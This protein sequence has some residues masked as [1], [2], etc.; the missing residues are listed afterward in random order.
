MLTASSPAW[1]VFSQSVA[2]Y[3][4][5]QP[6]TNVIARIAKPSAGG[7][8]VIVPDLMGRTAAQASAMLAAVGLSPGVIDLFAPGKPP[9]KV[10]DQ[11]PSFGAQV[12]VGSLV[13]MKV[14]KLQ[15]GWKV[16]PPLAGLTKAQAVA[17]V[18]AA[19]LQPDPDDVVA[20]GKPPG[21]VFD[22]A[23][24]AGVLK[25]AGSTVAF[26]VA[27]SL[28]VIVP[29]VVGLGQA[30][31]QAALAAAGLGANVSIEVA[32]L[33]PPGKVFDQN[34]NAGALVGNGTSIQI[35]IAGGFLPPAVAIIPSVF[36]KTKAQAMAILAGV[37]FVGDPIEVVALG[38]PVGLVFS[39][40]PAGGTGA[41]LGTV[42][43]FKV[44]KPF[45]VLNVAVPNL[46][47]LTPFQAKNALLALGLGTNGK[48][49]LKLGKPFNRVYSQS[50]SPNVFVPK[51][52]VISWKANP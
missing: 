51:G 18:L 22:Q 50:I 40:S 5:V 46:I 48:I 6:G 7:T 10:F 45:L 17:A 31:A 36:G 43:Q 26:K 28:L 29:P 44:A 20:I 2:A 8:T 9:L 15:L 32:P 13:Q 19:G 33:K 47:N 52:T 12:P 21:K 27:K 38:H 3:T 14:A 41:A 35:R 37:G 25:P 30:Q 11:A 34:P 49:E 1:R 16:V 39:Q 42:V 23:P 24:P 4:Q